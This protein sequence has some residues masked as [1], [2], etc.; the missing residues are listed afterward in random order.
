MLII[1]LHPLWP[2]ELCIHMGVYLVHLHSQSPTMYLRQTEFWWKRLKMIS[3]WTLWLWILMLD[4]FARKLTGEF[5]ND[6]FILLCNLPFLQHLKP[7]IFTCSIYKAAL[8]SKGSINDYNQIAQVCVVHASPSCIKGF[9][10]IYRFRRTIRL[11]YLGCLC[12]ELP[13]EA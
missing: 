9:E 10:Y 2:F 13:S 6:F 1:N 7:L 11:N 8:K 3:F 4:L 5:I 12:L